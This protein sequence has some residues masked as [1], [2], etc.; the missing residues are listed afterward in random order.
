MTSTRLQTFVSVAPGLEPA[1][2]LDLRRRAPEVD[3]KRLPGGFEAFVEPSV[4]IRLVDTLA[5]AEAVRVRV[6]HLE[7][8]TFAEL[9]ERMTRVNLGALLPPGCPVSVR[10]TCQK[11]RLYHSDAVAERVGRELLRRGHTLED[12]AEQ[13]LYV[14]FDH[15]RATLSVD[16]AGIPLHRRGQRSHVAAASMRETLAAALVSAVPEGVE[17]WVD[18]FCGAGTLLLEA[19]YWAGGVTAV[20]TEQVLPRA[21]QAW[22][23]MKGWVG[24]ER[25]ARVAAPLRLLGGDL[26]EA[27]LVA[28][29]RNLEHVAPPASFTARRQDAAAT[30]AESPA[31]AWVV[32]NPPYGHRLPPRELREV[33]ERF[34]RALKQSRAAGAVV[35]NGFHGFE[36]ATRLE[37]ETLA[38]TNNRGLPVRLLRWQR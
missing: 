16:A 35:M 23:T 25:S 3:F 22:P 7:A 34:G 21:W 37:W 38:V 33:F 36:Q 11:S 31:G 5:A 30:V 1:L 17:A 10:V 20:P 18:P 19:C 29:A 28:C 15:D 13:R 14:R 8:L 9:E 26:D 6:G 24:A 12:E 4:L 32:A 27:A 2:A